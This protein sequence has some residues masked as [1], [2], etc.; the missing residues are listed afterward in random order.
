VPSKAAE[1]VLFVIDDNSSGSSG[2]I[3]W[4]VGGIDPSSKGVAAGQVPAGGIVGTNT[5]GKAGYSA[6]CP[7]KGKSDTIE[8]VMY[9]LKKT[10]PLSPG[11]QPAQAESEYGSA[12]LAIGQ[13]A[14]TYG[15]ASR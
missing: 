9:A 12:K 1:L 5:A 8:F 15:I 10:I 11:F 13:A 7:D 2:G 4:I 14:V 6:I 3:R